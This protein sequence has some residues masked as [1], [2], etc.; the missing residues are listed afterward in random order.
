M[1]TGHADLDERFEVRSAEPE[2]VDRMLS[3][4]VKSRL[5][6][7]DRIRLEVDGRR[8]TVDVPGIVDDRERIRLLL[9][10]GVEV[11]AAID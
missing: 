3:D 6:W 8:V 4:R 2:A 9:D 1:A 11:A 7:E 5:L 10:F